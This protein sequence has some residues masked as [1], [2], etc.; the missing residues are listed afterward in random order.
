MVQSFRA[1]RREQS[2]AQKLHS[3]FK[4]GLCS[5]LFVEKQ[6]WDTKGLHAVDILNVVETFAQSYVA[7]D[8][9]AHAKRQ[10]P[11]FALEENH[12]DMC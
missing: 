5:L 8:A 2:R 11:V 10:R 6:L 1:V 3:H 7:I 4:S 12:G 9:L